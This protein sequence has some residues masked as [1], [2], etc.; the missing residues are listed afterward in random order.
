VILYVYR[1][2]YCEKVADEYDVRKYIQFKH[3]VSKL[4]WDDSR[5]LWS[6]ECDN[7]K[8]LYTKFCIDAEGPL[9]YTNIPDIAGQ[10]SF[11][12]DS[13]HS[14][15]WDSSVKLHNKRV[16]VIGSGASSIQIVPELQKIVSKLLVFQRTAGWLIPRSD[17][18]VQRWLKWAYTNIPLSQRIIRGCMYFF[19]EGAVL[20]FKYNFPTIYLTQAIAY[21]ILYFSVPNKE[22]REKLTPNFK[23]GCKRVMVSDDWYPALQKSNVEVIT[24]SIDHIESDGIVTKDGKKHIVD[25]I[26]YATGYA[27]QRGD[28]KTAG[29]PII[30]RDGMALSDLWEDHMFAY[31][32]SAVPHF[33]NLFWMLGKQ[34]MM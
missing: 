7:D 15:Q 2:D 13:F 20:G 33:P 4:Q 23:L 32:S 27:I 28:H 30:G 19:R 14:G 25:V 16:A 9:S 34:I 10:K 29:F 17:K 31:K 8:R 3:T 5:R 26:V 22:L 12:G 18:T 11:K 1:W 24:D 6:V 21:A